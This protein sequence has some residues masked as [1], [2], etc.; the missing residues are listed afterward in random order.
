MCGCS[1]NR[2]PCGLFEF[3]WRLADIYADKL[4][5]LCQIVMSFK[6][7][8]LNMITIVLFTVGT[9]MPMF[10]PYSVLISS[11]FQIALAAVSI[12]LPVG[13]EH[14]AHSRDDCQDWRAS[15][16][17]EHTYEWLGIK[18]GP[19]MANIGI[20][21]ISFCL[22]LLQ[23]IVL[24]R[25]RLRKSNGFNPI[26]LLFP[27]SESS[28]VLHESFG[29]AVKF[30][31]NYWFYKL[32]L[33][34]TLAT[35]CLNAMLRMDVVGLLYFAIIFPSAV[36]NRRAVKVLWV[37]FTVFFALLM[38]LQY[39]FFVGFPMCNGE[40]Y[41][42]HNMI[43]LKEFDENLLEFLGWPN[44][45]RYRT[46]LM[47][48]KMIFDAVTLLF[49]AA[50]TYCFESEYPE[51][52][53]G[54][55][56]SGQDFNLS[57]LVKATAED[58]FISNPRSSF[59][60]IRTCVVM[61]LHW[62]ALV[63]YLIAGLGGRSVFNVVYLVIAFFV[64]WQGH[65]TYMVKTLKRTILYWKLMLIFSMVTMFL[66]IY[67]QFW[68]CGFMPSLI[69]GCALRQWFS[70]VCSSPESA[71]R[72]EVWVS[73]TYGKDPCCLQSVKGESPVDVIAFTFVLLHLR[74]LKSKVFDWCVLEMYCEAIQANSGAILINQL[75]SKEVHDQ[76]EKQ[77][78][79]LKQIAKRAVELK[80]NYE[81]KS[82]GHHF[83]PQTYS[84]A[85]L[86][87]D[88]YMFEY[89]PL[90][91]DMSMDEDLLISL[92]AGDTPEDKAT[93]DPLQVIV[94][95]VAQDFDF[96][97]AL[98]AIENAESIQDEE[99]RMLEAVRK[100]PK[101]NDNENGSESIESFRQ[102]RK[103]LRDEYATDQPTKHKKSCRE[104]IRMAGR[105]ASKLFS[106]IIHYFS[107]F[108]RRHSRQQ[109]YVSFVLKKEKCKL[110]SAILEEL[111]I[112]GNVI[113]PPVDPV[114]LAVD[115]VEKVQREA[116]EAEK[117]IQ[118]CCRFL[119]SIY[120]FISANTDSLCFVLAIVAHAYGGGMITMP[121]P[122]MIFFW[123]SL[124]NPRAEKN[125]WICM[126]I[127]TQVI[128]VVKC[129][130][131]IDPFGDYQFVMF[132]R[133]FTKGDVL[134]YLGLQKETTFAVCDVALLLF[135]F[136]HRYMLQRLGLWRNSLSKIVNRSDSTIEEE[137][138]CFIQFFQNVINPK[139]RFIG[140]VYSST[141]LL[142]L[143]CVLI[144]MLGYSAFADTSTDEI[145]VIHTSRI[146]I[147]LVIT[148]FFL[149]MLIIIDR[150]LYLRKAV[151]P[152]LLYHFIVVLGLHFW[153]FFVIPFTT[154]TSIPKNYPAQAF[155]ILKGISLLLSGWQIKNGYPPLCTGS[156]L[157][158]NYG[159]TSFVMFK[160]FM[161]LP[162][163]FE[164][165]SAIDWT[166]TDTAMPI[167][168]FIKFEIFFSNVYMV[169]CGRQMEQNFP[170]PRGQKKSKASKHS[171]GIPIILVLVIL[172]LS[173]ILIFSVLNF[174]G[175]SYDPLKMTMEISFDTLPPFYQTTLETF[176]P[177][178]SLDRQDI[179]AAY[180][181]LENDADREA[182]DEAKKARLAL[183]FLDEFTDVYKVSFP[184][185]SMASWDVS[186]GA[187]HELYEILLTSNKSE[188]HVSLSLL[189]G[190]PKDKSQMSL[191]IRDYV[192][193]L[194][195]EIV[196]NLTTL[197]NQSFSQHP[198]FSQKLYIPC[199][200]PYYML[201]PS[202][203]RIELADSMLKA[204]SNQSEFINT[205]STMLLTLD[206][207]KNPFGFY[208]KIK[209]I[210]PD[211]LRNVSIPTRDD[212]KE[213]HMV[214]FFDRMF[215]EVMRTLSQKSVIPMYFAVVYVA[216]KFIRA[217]IFSEPLQVII[218]EMPNPDP[219]L[220]IFFDLY[221]VREAQDFLLEEE[222]FAKMIFL[223]RSP[224]T[225]IKWS[226]FK[227]KK[228]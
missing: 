6:I 98:N 78:R 89:D 51:H 32:G 76:Y 158:K 211:I 105:F 155:Y 127:Y 50:Q 1:R 169:K 206:G 19:L 187:L 35:M 13:K 18:S 225:L 62:V 159:F 217:F 148:V 29:K 192:V 184:D 215:P 219:L 82:N 216:F 28:N 72:V 22:I 95:L 195:T 25:R 150:A 223:F 4:G 67:I 173:P 132:D 90:K 11:V 36:L 44:K 37:S 224:G 185:F 93:L 23:S 193:G 130:S 109:R 61:S 133:T 201:I 123:G 227:I 49:M 182:D 189:R 92:D 68:A 156:F 38:V 5:L 94:C 137:Y 118:P 10:G 73:N 213:Y 178:T 31:F 180:N 179:V 147:S 17:I 191:H 2:A 40:N 33:E 74:L 65:A 203:E 128:I 162:F 194:N 14:R 81:N 208:W 131:Q 103:Q 87:G 48:Q 12:G 42:W 209:L 64:L 115:D 196:E 119:L 101:D 157:T 168:D 45:E 26:V 66:K 39:A 100:Q 27:D 3:L 83:R 91:D 57:T 126:M 188:V 144:V 177:L 142:D 114:L 111:R 204:V 165:R 107:S 58:D 116:R 110:K 181:N 210:K 53:A 77:V 135:L 24:V 198:D 7:C 125:F 122:L 161:N 117:R 59:D 55:N 212:K 221:L 43:G 139:K 96:E 113:A 86:S 183:T 75:I 106:A 199:A 20:I 112:S 143:I 104:K 167:F 140:D 164:L 163:A 102:R 228:E 34:T 129:L 202:Y 8:A 69:N 52:P 120:S 80:K 79:T 85:K 63:S 15:S 200:I 146:P 54:D 197:I 30:G 71:A 47:L 141:F 56:V 99:L 60:Y 84:Q 136:F 175:E 170:V 174:I 207:G 176:E 149:I 124:S 220:K 138:N 21:V 16:N 88:Y 160:A 145:P 152:K 218:K 214:L 166:W 222:L 46:G 41:P 190:N 205:Y 154:R 108:L 186:K 153:L 171:L 70:I 121:L 134:Y 226:R 172:I 97:D 9:C 151:L